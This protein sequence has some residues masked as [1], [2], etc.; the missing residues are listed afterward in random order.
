MVA[1]EEGRR[2]AATKNRITEVYYIAERQAAEARRSLAEE[3]LARA[4]A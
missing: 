2:R 1:L 3:A 4:T